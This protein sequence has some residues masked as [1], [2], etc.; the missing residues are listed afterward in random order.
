MKDLP[1]IISVETNPR[2]IHLV[3]PNDIVLKMVFELSIGD[4]LGI[5]TYCIPYIAIDHVLPQLVAGQYSRSKQQFIK[6]TEEMEHN[7]AFAM[8]DVSAELGKTELTVDDVVHLQVGDIIPLSAKKSNDL[9]VRVGGLR[10][11]FG[12]LGV[13]DKHYAVKINQI[14]AS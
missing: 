6:K 3:Q 11:F 5:F 14:I 4:S 10:K 9:V 2:V 1:R 7:L 8:V 13:S 12:E